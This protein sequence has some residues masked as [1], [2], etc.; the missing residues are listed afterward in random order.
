MK[1][2]KCNNEM[3]RITTDYYWN[4][5]RDVEESEIIY[6]CEK[7]GTKAQVDYSNEAVVNW[8][9][10]YTAQHFTFIPATMCSGLPKEEDSILVPIGG[11]GYTK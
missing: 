3:D 5:S 8:Q 4:S 2:K 6:W 9:Q 1:C 10:P 7:C 11:G